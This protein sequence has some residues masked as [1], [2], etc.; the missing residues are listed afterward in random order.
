MTVAFGTDGSVIG[1]GGCNQFRGS[2]TRPSPVELTIGQLIVT[3]TVCDPQVMSHEDQYLDAL[4]A[5]IGLKTPEGTSLWLTNPT[6]RLEFEPILPP[7]MVGTNWKLIDV[8]GIRVAG[9]ATVTIHLSPDASVFGNA[10]CDP[11]TA[12][13]ELRGASIRF[14]DISTGERQCDEHTANLQQSYLTMLELVDG[15]TMRDGNL[16]LTAAGQELRFEP[17]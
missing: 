4:E 5:S 14:G 11:Y 2:F 15:A 10:G 9:L 12:W 6:A 17:L 16:V 3:R 7:E 1:W 8:A 13:Y